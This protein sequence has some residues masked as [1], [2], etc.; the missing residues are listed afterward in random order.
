VGSYGTAGELLIGTQLTYGWGQT[1]AIDPYLVPNEYAAL[2]T[3]RYAV[4]IILAGSTT[5]RSIKRAVKQIVDPSA[6][7]AAPPPH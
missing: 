7:P 1:L 6:A 4:M 3:R 5:L 2:D